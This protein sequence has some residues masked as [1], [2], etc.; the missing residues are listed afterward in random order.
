MDSFLTGVVAACWLGIL[1]SVSPCPLAANIAAVSYVGKK[2][3]KTYLVLLSG[4]L[5]ILGRMIAYTALGVVLVAGVMSVSNLSFMLQEHV[6]T[7]LGPLLILVGILLLG[8]V[9]LNL[10]TPGIGERMQRRFDSWG[11]LGSLAIGIVFAFSFCPIS[12]A[13]F[14]GSLIPLSV[15]YQSPFLMPSLY[16]VGTGLPV[17]AFA[18]LI[19]A[20]A[21]F[22]GRAF[23]KI[24]QAELWARRVTGAIFV[25]VGVYYSLAYIFRVNI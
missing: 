21:K 4:L 23:D 3:D 13:L 12:A 14:F 10:L 6:N 22:I 8:I 11:L 18:L 5:Y 24:K 20:S 25:L 16:G 17:F 1:T 19:A 2:V 7:F 15:K 9:R